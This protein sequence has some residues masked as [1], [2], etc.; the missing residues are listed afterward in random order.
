MLI[1]LKLMKKQS[2]DVFPCRR[3]EAVTKIKTIWAKIE[4]FKIIELNT[5]SV[6]DDR[7]IKPK[8]RTCGVKFILTFAV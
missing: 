5:L 2:I 8:I 4:D 1:H 6:F 7:Y 3:W